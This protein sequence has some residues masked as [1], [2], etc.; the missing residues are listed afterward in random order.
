MDI[1]GQQNKIMEDRTIELQ[2]RVENEIK[3]IKDECEDLLL[4]KETEN[5]HQVELLTRIINEKEEEVR[6]YFM[7]EDGEK[8]HFLK[9]V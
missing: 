6:K 4:K 2:H 7:V 5:Q 8:I 9:L 3:L 1:E